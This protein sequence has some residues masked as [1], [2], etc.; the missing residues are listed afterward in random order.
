M[1]LPIDKRIEDFTTRLR[2]A[3]IYYTL[4]S[5]RDGYTMV[6][7][8][9]PGERWEVEFEVSGDVE[10]EVFKSDGVIRGAEALARLFERFSDAT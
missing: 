10:V 9:V 1:T 8:A 5:V 6:S 4:G 3:S 2:A 7:I